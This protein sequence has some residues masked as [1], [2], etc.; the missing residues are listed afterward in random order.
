MTGMSAVE[1]RDGTFG[2]VN[3]NKY[4]VGPGFMGN[5]SNGIREYS[6]AGISTLSLSGMGDRVIATIETNSSNIN[7][8]VITASY[9]PRLTELPSV[10][11]PGKFMTR[12]GRSRTS[13]TPLPS[14][15]PVLSETSWLT[16]Y[17]TMLTSKGEAGLNSSMPV[18][19]GTYTSIDT[20]C[21]NTKPKTCE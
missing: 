18:L 4:R 7:N 19:D 15:S 9:S 17:Q 10:Y 21:Q 20:G 6:N 14:I 1:F 12:P 16:L 3:G 2:M 11:I 5:T 13:P 8:S